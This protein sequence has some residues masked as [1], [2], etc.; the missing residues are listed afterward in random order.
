MKKVVVSNDMH[1]F[2][3][4]FWQTR[5]D[6]KITLMTLNYDLGIIARIPP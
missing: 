1:E 4:P 3:D 5:L 2:G 6:N